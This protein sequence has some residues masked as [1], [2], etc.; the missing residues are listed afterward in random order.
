MAK[1]GAQ[2]KQKQAKKTEQELL[3]GDLESSSAS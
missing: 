1:I 3:R 2:S